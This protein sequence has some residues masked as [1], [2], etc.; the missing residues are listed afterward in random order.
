MSID[1]FKRAHTH[2]DTD[3]SKDSLHHT[4]GSGPN[5]AAPGSLVGKVKALEQ[6]LEAIK[7]LLEN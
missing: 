5:Q 2:P 3:M 7:A 4:L 6:E 1:A